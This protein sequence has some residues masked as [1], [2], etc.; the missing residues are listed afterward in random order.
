MYEFCSLDAQ[1][2]WLLIRY[3]SLLLLVKYSF[4]L[5]FGVRQYGMEIKQEVVSTFQRQPKMF[6]LGLY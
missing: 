2:I 5:S 3:V 1:Y 4:W 6:I